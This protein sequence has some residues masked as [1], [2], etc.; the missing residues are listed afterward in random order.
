MNIEYDLKE[1]LLDIK[2]DIAKLDGKLD[3]LD[4]KVDNMS[5][6]LS[7][8]KIHVAE[9]FGALRGDIV[10]V[11]SILQGEIKVL[12]EK[13]DGLGKRVDTQEFINRGII[14]GLIL[15]VLGGVKIFRLM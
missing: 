4:E 15:A 7:D 6:D 2:Q 12:S 10:R 8:F 3:K 13:V 9:D 11:E 14:V 5:K 1:V